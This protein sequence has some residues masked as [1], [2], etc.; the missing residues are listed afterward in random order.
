[1]ANKSDLQPLVEELRMKIS[2]SIEENKD[3]FREFSEDIYVISCG[4]KEFID[5]I[6]A[7]H[8][9]PSHRVYANTFTFDEK[10]DIVGFDKD[11]VLAGHNGKI[12]CLKNLDLEGEVQV[13]GDGYSDYVMREAGIAH[14][15]FAYTEN[16]HREKATN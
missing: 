15:F 6:V 14:K 10:G 2:R 1:R 11:N 12:D 7:E 5:P 9:I 4:F 8:N 13:I 16:V 3:F